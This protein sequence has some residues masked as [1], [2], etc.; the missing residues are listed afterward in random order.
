MK[1]IAVYCGSS[2]GSHT[3]FAEAAGAL[4]REMLKRD[5]ALVYGGGNVG[6]MGEIAHALVEGGGEVIGVIPEFLMR[7]EVGMVDGI[8]LRIVPDM[9]T[10]K[11]TISTVSDAFI[12]MPGGL[13]TL[14]EITEALTWAQ[15][16]IHQK[17]CAFYNVA[18][19]YDK[20]ID[21][22]EHAIENGFIHPSNRALIISESDPAALLDRL[23]AYTP[24]ITDK[25]EFARRMSNHHEKKS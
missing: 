17:P 6:L 5:L 22:I 15:L 4:G 13:G 3:A 24:S 1:S 23:T 2:V 25:A 16:G 14:E 12:A 18:G 10:R 11:S 19:F 20:L 8:D 9:H 7:L 21:F